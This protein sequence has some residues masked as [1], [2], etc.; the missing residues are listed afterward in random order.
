MAYETVWW[1]QTGA[2]GLSSTLTGMQARQNLWESHW[3]QHRVP[4]HFH[5]GRHAWLHKTEGTLRVGL[6]QTSQNQLV[7]VVTPFSVWSGCLTHS[8]AT[9]PVK[10]VHWSVS[11]LANFLSFQAGP[12]RRKGTWKIHS[13][14]T[15]NETVLTTLPTHLHPFSINSLSTALTSEKLG[16]FYS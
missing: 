4:F 6:S 16:H 2:E 10:T 7:A 14:S 13:S 11:K 5:L 8:L 12:W 15:T 3:L 1:G 9:P